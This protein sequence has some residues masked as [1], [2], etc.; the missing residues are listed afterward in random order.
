MS[1]SC[2]MN[3]LC[4]NRLISNMKSLIRRNCQRTRKRFMR[5]HERQHTEHMRRIPA[6]M[7]D[8]GFFWRM[9]MSLRDQIANM[10]RTD[11]P[12]VPNVLPSGEPMRKVMETMYASFV[13]QEGGRIRR[14][15][16]ARRLSI[17]VGPVVQLSKNLKR[18]YRGRSLFYFLDGRDLS[19]V[20]E[21]I[22]NLFPLRR[23]KM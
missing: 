15:E 9:A 21:G 7:W 22:D 4:V 1:D 16:S 5:R 20:K 2:R 6:F 11:L 13:L 8:R 17:P 23:M 3:V 12:H 19:C 18:E 10:R 14:R